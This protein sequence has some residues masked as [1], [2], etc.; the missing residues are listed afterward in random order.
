MSDQSTAGG[1]GWLLLAAIVGGGW[2]YLANT[3]EAKKA[4]AERAAHSV[5]IGQRATLREGFFYCRSVEA[6]DW[7]SKFAVE[8]DREAWKTAVVQS[9]V[10]DT[11]RPTKAGEEITVTDVAVWKELYSFRFL[12]QTD[13]WWT[14]QKGV[15]PK[16]KDS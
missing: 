11:C 16:P 9:Y 13:T 7:I 8:N 4:A 15:L 6:V 1:G 2:L 3:P 12:G 5:S 14:Y 10:S